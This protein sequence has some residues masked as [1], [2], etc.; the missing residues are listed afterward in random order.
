MSFEKQVIIDTGFLV[1]LFQ[2]DDTEHLRALQVEQE[3]GDEWQFVSSLFVI[4]ETCWIISSRSDHRSVIT[5][6]EHIRDGFLLIPALPQDWIE[7]AL[8]ILSKYSDRNLDLADASLVV[9][10]DHLNLGNILTVDKKDFL[11]LRWGN[12]KKQFNNLMETS[13]PKNKS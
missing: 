6:M 4:Q 5:F 2:E 8:T 10:A 13:F 3:L 1:A 9:L 12:G 11:V 7:K